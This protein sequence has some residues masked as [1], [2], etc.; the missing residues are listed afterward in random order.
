MLFY[1]FYIESSRIILEISNESGIYST[2]L[3]GPL[4]IQILY[5][6]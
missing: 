1:S 6:L 5:E 3:K 2:L 4:L